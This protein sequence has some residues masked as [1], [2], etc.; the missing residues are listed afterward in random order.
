MGIEAEVLETE[1]EGLGMMSGVFE[2]EA[3]G[4]GTEGGVFETERSM[5]CDAEFNPAM[6]S[7]LG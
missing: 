5:L 2:T 3:E 4:L 7:G 6:A 1:V